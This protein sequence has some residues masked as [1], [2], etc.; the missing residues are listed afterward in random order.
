MFSVR[1]VLLNVFLSGLLG[2]KTYF[3]KVDSKELRFKMSYS[4]SV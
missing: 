4:Q 1:L 2:W 3:L